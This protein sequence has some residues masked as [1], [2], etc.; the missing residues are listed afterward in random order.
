MTNY[1]QAI[2]ES[3]AKQGRVGAADPRHVEAWMRVEHGTLDAL[4]AGQFDREVMI[5]VACAIDDPATSERL[6][7]AEGL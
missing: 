5:G 6:A 1:Q 7:A 2:R 4:S 3:M